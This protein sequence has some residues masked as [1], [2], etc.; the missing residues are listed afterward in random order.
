MSTPHI[1][2]DLGDFA[3]VVLM[4]GDPLRATYVAEQHLEEARLVTNVRNASG[5][6]GTYK[7]LAVSVMTSG[8]GMPSAAIYM[9]EL[10]RFYDV[11]TIIRIGTAGVFDPSLELRRIVAATECIT[12]S[13]M[14]SHL[15]PQ[16]GAPLTP[17]PELVAAAMQTAAEQ[18]VDLVMGKIFTTDIFYE[19]DQGLNARMAA[20]GALCV[21]METAGLYALARLEGRRALSL[22]TMSDHLA[23]GEHLSPIERQSTLDEMI[24]FSLEVVLTDSEATG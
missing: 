17:T 22:L 13:T 14:P 18:N 24:E 11:K 10:Y 3:P 4:P 9:T 15:L 2:A 21:E 8:M 7:G 16:D 23:T 6:T 5:Y 20:D 19:P 1:D 12:N